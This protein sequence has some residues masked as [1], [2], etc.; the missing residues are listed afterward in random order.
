MTKLTRRICIAVAISVLAIPVSWFLIQRSEAFDV[1]STHIK[2][3][4]EVRAKIGE[5]K[6]IDLP[7]FGYS[8]RVSGASGRANFNLELTG[9]RASANAD[10]ELTRQGTWR[11]VVSRLTLQDGTVVDLK[12]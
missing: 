5:I 2:N 7:L 1:A 12:P 9:S 11:P 8:W 3:S 10:V 6:E 4:A